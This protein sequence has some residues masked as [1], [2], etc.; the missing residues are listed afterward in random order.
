MTRHIKE[1]SIKFT[2]ALHPWHDFNIRTENLWGHWL[3]QEQGL[4]SS[5]NNAFYVPLAVNDTV[6]VA[7]EGSGTWQVV[8]I[9]RLAESVVT[10]TSFEPPMT[11]KQ[12]LAVYD[13]WVHDGKAV[14]TEGPGGGMMVTAWREFLSVE[15][16]LETL[17]QCS[18]PG[19]STWQ[20]LTPEQRK[21]ALAECVDLGH[22]S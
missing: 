7:N 17:S 22:D 20:I 15:E 14:Y 8:E 11:P 21:Q 4:V 13:G 12:A 18:T 9:V 3:D 19:W 10:T 2:L 5:M 1:P 16:V 6:R